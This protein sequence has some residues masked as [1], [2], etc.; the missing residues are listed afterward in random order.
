M[1][2]VV[3]EKIEMTKEQNKRLEQIGDVKWFD[4]SNEE[5]CR[6]RI[7]GADVVVADWIDP[8]DF[9]LSMTSPSLLALMSTGY[10]WIKHRIEARKQGIL[11]SNIPGYATEAV[12][13]H[14]IGLALCVARQTLVGD[15]NIRVGKKEKGYLRGVELRGRRMGII[16]LGQTG[17][18]VA[19]I[20]RCLGMDIA[21]Y[22]RHPK[23]SKGVKDVSLKELLSSSDVVCVCCPLNSDSKGMLNKDNLKLMKPN[24]IL[25]GVTWEI[26]VLDDLISLLKNGRIG[27]MGFD[28]AIEGSKIDLPEELLNLDNVVLTPH[29][30]YN[31]TEAKIRQVDICISNIEAFKKGKPMNIVN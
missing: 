25:V 18:R 16:G 3:L 20:S 27:G 22:N 15:R 11:I 14:I 29:I 8:S 4:S 1:K 23:S 17:K 13:E 31:T 10:G 24:A 26:A 6:D 19:D 7:K 21:T 30:G 2:I 28:V 9:I 12:A 5:E